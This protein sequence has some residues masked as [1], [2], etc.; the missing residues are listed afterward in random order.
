MSVS[1]S[2]SGLSTRINIFLVGSNC[3]SFS[4]FSAIDPAKYLSITKPEDASASHQGEPSPGYCINPDIAVD[5]K[6][7]GAAV[8]GEIRN[9]QGEKYALDH[10]HLVQS[11]LSFTF[12]NMNGRVYIAKASLDKDRMDLQLW[13]IEGFLRG[14][15]LTLQ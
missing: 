9:A 13:G 6:T 12:R 3:T 7:A 15:T 11:S 14:L 5:L 10:I 8:S 2:I 1:P 4:I